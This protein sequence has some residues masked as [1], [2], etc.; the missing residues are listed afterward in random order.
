MII[1]RGLLFIILFADVLHIGE[2][3]SNEYTV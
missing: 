1:R 3:L 2:R